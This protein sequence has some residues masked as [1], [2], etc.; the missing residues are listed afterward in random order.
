MLPSS[1]LIT[2][3]WG[4]GIRPFYAPLSPRN[5]GVAELLIQTYRDH[6]GRRKGELNEAVEGLEELGHDYRYV[7]GLSVL[8]DRR[9]RLEA[10]AAINPVEAR[11]VVFRIAHQEGLPTTPEERRAVLAQAASG[12][13]VT[14]GELEATLYGDLEDELLIRDFEPVDPEALVRQYNLSLTQTLLFHSTELTFTAAGNWQRL[15]RKIKWLGLIYTIQRSDGGYQVRVD[16]PT[17]LFKLH[18]RYGT[19]M[20]KLLPTIVQNRWWSLRAKILLRRGDRRLLNLELDSQ[21]HSRYMGTP[22]ALEEAYDSRVEEDFARRFRAL[23][24]GWSLIREPEPIPVGTQV[25]IPDFAFQKAGLR[26]YMEVVGFWTPQYLQ[27][28]LEKLRKAGGLDMIVA[29]DKELACRGLDRIGERL[30]VIH[31]RR[32]IPLRPVLDHLKA[33]EEHLSEEQARRLS[34][35]ALIIQKPVVE[36]REIAERLGVLEDAVREVLREVEVPGYTR[37]GDM[38]INETKLGEIRERLEERLE[39][40]ELGLEEAS[41]IIEVLGGRRPTSILD[42]LGY[43]IDWHGIDPRSAKIRR[44]TGRS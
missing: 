1:L 8:L 35:E 21:R 43:R 28:K 7:R 42:A 20:A 34:A 16:G 12:L 19:S 27:E 39:R 37:L 40:G 18:R 44:R 31:Y 30:N 33:R 38:L 24:T 11:G 9:C 23:D 26:V 3:R 2:R 13:G 41:E 15:F 25:M 17:S 36:A 14:A 5:L 10:H 29:A 4:G 32:H 6:V 22:E